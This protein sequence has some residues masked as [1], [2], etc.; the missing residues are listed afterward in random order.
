M[1]S[2]RLYAEIGHIEDLSIL[3][4]YR[5][6]DLGQWKPNESA[7]TENKYS[8]EGKWRFNFTELILSL[9]IPLIYQVIEL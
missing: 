3:R 9:V 4:I 5:T 2:F 1:Q 7:I 6:R 8:W